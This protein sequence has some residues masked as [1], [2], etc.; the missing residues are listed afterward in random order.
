MKY[1]EATGATAA[2]TGLLVPFLAA[3][4]TIAALAGIGI[5]LPFFAS[6]LLSTT[7]AV[8][9]WLAAEAALAS[10]FVLVATALARREIPE[11]QAA[12]KKAVHIYN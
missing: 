5:A 4:M 10:I 7:G 9:L 3:I 11:L 12:L 2:A 1:S 6:K 8:I